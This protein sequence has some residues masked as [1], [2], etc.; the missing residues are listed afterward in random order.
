MW[1]M[2]WSAAGGSRATSSCFFWLVFECGLNGR[3]G[4]DKRKEAHKKVQT[5]A[6]GTDLEQVVG[7]ARPR[8]PVRVA[9]RLRDR[10][11]PEGA[12]RH[13]RL[14][15]LRLLL[16]RRRRRHL[17]LFLP[18]PRPRHHRGRRHMQAEDEHQEARGRWGHVPAGGDGGEEGRDEVGAEG[19][20]LGGAEDGE[21]G[22]EP[23]V[24]RAAVCGFVFG[25][26]QVSDGW[27]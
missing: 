21:E 17:P 26:G 22:L 4:S 20:E 11:E 6:C 19:E 25:W 24:A 23:R 12:H 27:S 8:G 7:D 2:R 5:A 15:L 18:L 9:E 14:L 3:A 16:R 1:P 13:H 10:A